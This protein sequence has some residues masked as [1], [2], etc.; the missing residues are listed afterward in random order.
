MWAWYICPWPSSPYSFLKKIHSLTDAEEVFGSKEAQLS[1]SGL[2]FLS[3]KDS[4]PA[5]SFLSISH[6][7]KTHFVM[8]AS[9]KGTSQPLG[10]DCFGLLG[11]LMV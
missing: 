6:L 2:K 4:S 5:S 1:S 11:L 3:Q 8:D 9:S 10:F 7:D